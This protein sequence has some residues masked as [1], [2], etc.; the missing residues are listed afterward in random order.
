MVVVLLFCGWRRL[1]HLNRNITHFA[2]PDLDIHQE[3]LK[4]YHSKNVNDQ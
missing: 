4:L 2:Q 1:A 3:L